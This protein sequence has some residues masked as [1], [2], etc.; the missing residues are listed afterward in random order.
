MCTISHT[1]VVKE[2]YH[3]LELEEVVPGRANFAGVHLEEQPNSAITHHIEMA[4]PISPEVIAAIVLKAVH[5]QAD[6]RRTEDQIAFLQF[7]EYLFC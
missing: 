1:D 2:E 6:A 7:T 5:S 3:L 4:G